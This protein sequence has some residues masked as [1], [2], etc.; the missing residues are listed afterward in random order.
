MSISGSVT[1]IINNQD[2]FYNGEFSGSQLVV[3][4]QSLNPHCDKFKNVSIRAGVLDHEFDR[5]VYLPDS[6]SVAD[7]TNPDTA[8]RSGEILFLKNVN[9][10]TITNIKISNTTKTSTDLS[11]ILPS[12]NNITFNFA[13]SNQN[14]NVSFAGGGSNYTAFD[15]ISPT[16]TYDST[17]FTSN[18]LNYSA[19][20]VRSSSLDNVRISDIQGSSPLFFKYEVPITDFETETDPSGLFNTSSGIYTSPLTNNRLLSVT[21]SIS[22]SYTFQNLTTATAS[23][24]IETQVVNS[25]RGDIYSTTGNIRVVSPGVTDVFRFDHS[26]QNLITPSFNSAFINGDEIILRSFIDFSANIFD[27]NGTGS[28]NISSSTFAVNQIPAPDVDV[29]ST[30]TAVEPGYLSDN[31]DFIHSFD[32]QPLFNNVMEIRPGTLYYVVDYTQ[33]NLIPVNIIPIQSQS[34]EPARIPDSNYTQF[35]HISPRYLGTKLTSLVYNFYSPPDTSYQ[36]RLLTRIWEGD[37]SYGK[38]PVI[39]RVKPNFGYFQ[40]LVP[41]SPELEDATQVKLKYLIDKEGSPFKPLLNSP[42]F[43]NVEGTFETNDRIDIALE[44]TLQTDDP[45]L[46]NAAVGVNLDN[47]NISAPVIRGARRVDPI[48]TTQVVSVF[49]TASAPNTQNSAFSTSS[50]NFPSPYGEVNNYYFSTYH[51]ASSVGPGLVAFNFPDD[52]LP[53]NQNGLT[54]AAEGLDV[55]IDFTS[56]VDDFSNG[57]SV[58]NDEYTFP[59]TPIP[60]NTIRFRFSGFIRLTTTATIPDT[61]DIARVSI[62]KRS[63]GVDTR[64]NTFR[65]DYTTAEQAVFVDIDTQPRSYESGDKVFV[66]FLYTDPLAG[67]FQLNGGKAEFSDLQFQGIPSLLPSVEQA[68]PFFLTGSANDNYITASTSMSQDFNTVQ[69]E[70]YEN[71]TFKP[72]NEKFTVKVGDE[73]RFQGNEQLTHLVTEVIAFSDTG[74]T[75]GSLVIKVQPPVPGGI[76][77]DEFLL[78]RYNPDGTSVLIDLKPPSSS[79]A[80]TKGVIK[81]VTIDEKLE[82]NIGNILS[83]LS[84]EG[85]I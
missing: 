1:R 63:G 45:S 22:G 28:L 50:I 55:N 85:T 8:P 61:Q 58:V 65:L 81:N 69:Q 2:E 37:K 11:N 7:F 49:D 72:I 19:S 9:S 39:D 3:S 67:S 77:I 35:S 52:T 30:I 41:T 14:V 26:T 51:S 44:D 4:T 46:T 18:F 6:C 82:E 83:R 42:S 68:P 34:A 84:E 59:S 66:E 54:I 70:P 27:I 74:A 24:S 53:L 12:V 62:V 25:T 32:C 5:F 56:K 15:V 57:F 10:D 80:T 75:S 36:D 20:A 78:R 33:G 21:G 76:E 17:N 43:F 29:T 47:F 64:L 79:F 31:T 40:L 73:F 71:S 38:T 13:G 23:Y 48:L 60:G 16:F